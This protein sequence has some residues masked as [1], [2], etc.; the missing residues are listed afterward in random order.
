MRETSE[1]LQSLQALLDQ[2][3]EHAGA[4][5]RQSFQIPTHSFSA[6]QLVHFWQG[7]QTIALA[8]VTSKGEPRVAPISTLFF[9]GRFYVPTV[10]TAARTKHVIQHPAISFTYYQGNEVAIIVHG[11]ATVIQPDHPDFVAV[12][13]LQLEASG[14]SVLEWGEGVFL[15]ILPRWLYTFARN[16]DHYPED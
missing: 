4:F 2:S 9:R 14:H 15:Q 12:E 7:L 5:L 11:E 1:D 8:T 16:H 10:A 13:A 6:R 3:I